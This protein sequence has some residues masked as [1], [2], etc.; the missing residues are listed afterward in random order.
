[1]KEQQIEYTDEEG[2]QKLIEELHIQ[3]KEQINDDNCY[4]MTEDERYV[5]EICL[6]FYN[7]IINF[8]FIFKDILEILDNNRDEN[9][10]FFCEYILLFTNV[11]FKQKVI[12]SNVNYYKNIRFENSVFD[13]ETHFLRIVFNRELSFT[14]SIFNKIAN[15]S[16]S[17]FNDK[18]YFTDSIF[19]KYFS[20]Y[21]STYNKQTS[22][23]QSTFNDE[24][25]C[26]SSIFNKEAIFEET[27]FNSEVVLL[28]T[29]FNNGANFSRAKFNKNT[30]FASTKLNDIVIFDNIILN[31]DESSIVF[32]NID[33]DTSKD[34]NLKIKITNTI[35]KCRIE[36]YNIKIPKIDFKGSDVDSGIISR[37]NFEAYPDNWQTACFLKHEAIKRDNVVEAL[38]YKAIEK[39][40]HMDELL[41]KS[42]KN[43]QEWG[44]YLALA[45]SKLS[46]NHGQ[47]W[48]RAVLFTLYSCVICF[49]LFFIIVVS[50][51]LKTDTSKL[52]D[53]V[54]FVLAALMY[55]NPTNY[56]ILFYVFREMDIPI[57][58]KF[59]SAIPYILGKIAVG[60]GVVE[61]V[62]AFRKFN[63]KGN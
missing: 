39:D 53:F 51:W 23:V 25:D 6:S 21:H 3:I 52:F 28:M 2:Q 32:S 29:T 54:E 34:N 46:N 18:A 13:S 31:S 45:I 38:E 62:Q 5:K 9:G 59:I 44:E 10:D 36:F 4:T 40:L 60:Y 49:L 14:K 16:Q 58:C 1:M 19:H 48:L 61:V 17:T 27:I 56:D 22:F 55:I 57:I 11:T 42:G 35:I 50:S 7:I 26:T 24:V 41:K 20:S 43:A 15:F 47:D 33:V 30:Y 8:Q 37:I 63:T 12:F